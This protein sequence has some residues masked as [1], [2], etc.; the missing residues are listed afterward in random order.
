MFFA[1]IMKSENH[2]ISRRA[3]DGACTAIDASGRV[4]LL[5]PWRWPRHDIQL[6][7]GYSP[8]SSAL[9]HG[10]LDR[11]FVLAGFSYS[12]TCWAWRSISLSLTGTLLPAA[13]VIQPSETFLDGPSSRTVPGHAV[14]GFA[15]APLGLTADLARRHR[16][17]PFLETME[18]MIAS[19]EP[20]PESRS[21]ATGLNFLLDGGGGIRWNIRPRSALSFGYRFLHISNA[22]TSFNPGLNNNVSYV[23]YSLLR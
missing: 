14:Y 5:R 22:G 15:V 2:A 17:H 8:A 4:L 12:Y 23:G 3:G 7:A 21:N 10:A 6:L 13:I 11:R 20:I 16:V 1:T 9:I 19:T 18:G